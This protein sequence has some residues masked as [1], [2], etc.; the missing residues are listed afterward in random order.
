VVLPLAL[1]VVLIALLV[2][3]QRRRAAAPPHG[4]ASPAASTGTDR[5][6]L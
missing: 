6:T 1:P 5:P 2:R 3:W 4:P